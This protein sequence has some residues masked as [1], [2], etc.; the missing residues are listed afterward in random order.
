[1]K[2]L[3]TLVT[4]VLLII[5]AQLSAQ[6]C[7]EPAPVCC[8]PLPYN[9]CKPCAPI[10][11]QMCGAACYDPVVI[12]GIGAAIAAIVLLTTT[13]HHGHGHSHAH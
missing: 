10:C 2:A 13:H 3:K 11:G 7:Q 4:S 9:A 6:P 5:T 12:A 8:A 1:M